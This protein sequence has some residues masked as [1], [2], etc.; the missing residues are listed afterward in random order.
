MSV[1]RIG[2]EEANGKFSI[3]RNPGD[4]V[5]GENGSGFNRGCPPE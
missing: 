1:R 3:S 4:V 2:I 5:D